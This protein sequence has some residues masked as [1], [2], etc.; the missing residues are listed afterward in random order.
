MNNPQ[1]DHYDVQFTTR[2]LAILLGLLILI[3]GGVF[4]GG[5]LIG[6]NLAPPTIASIAPSEDPIVSGGTPAAPTPAGEP[7]V[8]AEPSAAS[9]APAPEP[10]AASP[11]PAAAPD[12]V[13]APPPA[14]ASLPPA[15]SGS[16]N[17]TIQVA[18]VRERSSAEQLQQALAALGLEAYLEAAPRGLIR[19]RVGRFESREAARETVALL[20]ANGRQAI[21]VPR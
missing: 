19:V 15:S 9:P 11:A 10:A 18:A 20:L 13:P 3:V 14:V 2:Q 21:V 12:P 8:S 4:V 6:R 7:A 16:G 5:I 1:D 17:F